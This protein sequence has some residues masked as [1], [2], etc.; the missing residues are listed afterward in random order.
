VQC[1]DSLRSLG[2]IICFLE[3]LSGYVLPNKL[4]RNISSQQLEHSLSKALDH[5]FSL[6]PCY[7]HFITWHPKHVDIMLVPNIVFDYS[8][9]G[10][11]LSLLLVSMHRN[12][13]P[14]TLLVSFR[15]I[16]ASGNLEWLFWWIILG[17]MT[18]HNAIHLPFLRSSC[19]IW[20][21]AVSGHRSGF[22]P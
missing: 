14:S 5:H 16:L 3:V 19:W 18:G 2:H 20:H 22:V 11:Y 13:F 15:T 8:Y 17:R 4:C 6:T 21:L 9:Q 7:V 10:K 12:I 1:A